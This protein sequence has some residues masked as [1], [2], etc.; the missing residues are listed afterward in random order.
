MLRGREPVERET[1]GR[2]ESLEECGA[3]VGLER[4]GLSGLTFGREIGTACTTTN[5]IIRHIGVTSY[6]DGGGISR[7]AIRP[8]ERQTLRWLVLSG[9]ST[10][11]SA[12]I[13]D[14]MDHVWEDITRFYEAGR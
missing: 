1:E 3:R 7:T 10:P 14:A 12:F 13:T 8:R 5:L 4:L 11:A 6:T 9:I 2:Y